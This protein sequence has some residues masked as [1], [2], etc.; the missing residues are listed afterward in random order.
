[1]KALPQASQLWDLFTLDP[2]K[3][4]LYWRKDATSLC[5]GHSRRGLPAGFLT[6]QRRYL[7]CEIDGTA[8]SVA[9]LIWKW[10]GNG[11]VPPGMQLDHRDRNS[12]NNQPWNLR[13]LTPSGNSLNRKTRSDNTSGIAGISIN[14]DRRRGRCVPRY[15]VKHRGKR[16]LST[17]DFEKAKAVKAR[18]MAEDPYG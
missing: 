10:L 8:Y 15:A 5:R 2:L 6:N 14:V 11:D 17:I 18:L 4:I 7:Y 3:G 16:V 12:T 9:G 1:M 13:L